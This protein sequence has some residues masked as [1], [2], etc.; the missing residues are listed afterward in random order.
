VL[1][2]LSGGAGFGEAISLLSRL[3]TRLV[4]EASRC[5]LLKGSMKAIAIVA[6]IALAVANTACTTT[7]K[8]VG[9][10]AVGGVFGAAVAGPIGAAAGAA[11]GAATAPSFVR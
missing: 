9:G 4:I 1:V 3:A 2:P 7:G 6:V 8:R 10:A 5:H 11:A